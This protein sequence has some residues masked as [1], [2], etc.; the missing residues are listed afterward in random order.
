MPPD[1]EYVLPNLRWTKIKGGR[2]RTSGLT[3]VLN[4]PWFTS[5]EGEQLAVL[6]SRVTDTVPT[7]TI[8][9]SF[10]NAG[11]EN[12]VSAWGVMQDWFPTAP[13]GPSQELITITEDTDRDGSDNNAPYSK[14][15][16]K[17]GIVQIDEGLFNAL[18]FT[19]RYNSLDGQW[20]VNLAL[21]KPPVY[22]A[23]VRLVVARYQANAVA[24]KQISSPSVCDFT[25]L[26]PERSVVITKSGWFGSKKRVQIFGVGT[27][28]PKDDKLFPQSIFEVGYYD[29]HDGSPTGFN[30]RRVKEVPGQV[31]EAGNSQLL[32]EGTFEEL[33]PGGKIVVQEREA[34]PSAEG[35]DATDTIPVY[36]DIIQL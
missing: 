14:N 21:S 25:V 10:K 11:E 9:T 7:A 26:R 20:Y 31:S 30:Y 1:I 23:V 34:W 33:I 28:V 5:G 13:P 17:Q 4:R 24:G 27:P 32:W 8:A 36:S 16:P 12:S 15:L 35:F 29:Q 19:P 3:L 6:T 2:T 22:G 18:F